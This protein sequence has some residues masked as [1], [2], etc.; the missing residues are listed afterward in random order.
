[1]KI[2]IF[3]YLFEQQEQKSQRWMLTR[4]AASSLSPISQKAIG[5]PD[6]ETTARQSTIPLKYQ[7]EN[8][9]R[10][11]QPI[12]EQQIPGNTMVYV[13]NPST[14]T[15]PSTKLRLFEKS[16]NESGPMVQAHT[17]VAD[18]QP[19]SVSDSQVNILRPIKMNSLMLFIIQFSAQTNK[20]NT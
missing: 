16:A 9:R 17:K 10:L 14:E 8:S 4:S 19:F 6:G 11:S 15:S 3:F 7:G 18:I 2:I 20:A 12:Q 5:N 1:M 13:Q